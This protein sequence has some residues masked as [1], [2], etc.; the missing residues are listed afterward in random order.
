[1]SAL[2]WTNLQGIQLPVKACFHLRIPGYAEYM[3]SRLI[4]S[5]MVFEKGEPTLFTAET[6]RAAVM[7]DQ[8]K[9]VQ[10][11]LEINL[12]EGHQLERPSPLGNIS[13]PSG[14]LSCTY[15]AGYR[16]STRTLM[17]KRNFVLC[18]N[19]SIA[20]RAQSYP[21][22]KRLFELQRNSDAQVFSCK[23]AEEPPSVTDAEN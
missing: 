22:I 14:I 9:S 20:Y 2:Q 7:F 21:A 23:T 6:R 5:P 15:K 16:K 12:P 13:D 10:D 17:I 4:F 1:M 8:A 3:N 11:E 18:G 19:G